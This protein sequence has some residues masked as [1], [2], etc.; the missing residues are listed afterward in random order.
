MVRA[1]HRVHHERNLER[2]HFPRLSPCRTGGV[3]KRRDG[4]P[5]D[6]SSKSLLAFPRFARAQAARVG[7][8]SLRIGLHER[9]VQSAIAMP[10]CA[11]TPRDHSRLRKSM[12]R[13]GA[14]EGVAPR[15]SRCC[16]SH[17]VACRIASASGPQRLVE[18]PD[19]GTVRR[20]LRRSWKR[21]R[22]LGCSSK[23]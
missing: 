16:G 13:E 1:L 14:V 10:N 3:F 9:A 22:R 11:R 7:I 12:R 17:G 19:V 5:S 15:C 20:A 21:T 4:P 2:R 18:S 6:D 8:I 23:Y